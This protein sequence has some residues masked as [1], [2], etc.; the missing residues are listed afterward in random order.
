M[1][2]NVIR[3]NPLMPQSP[4]PLVDGFE[5]T[6]DCS[7]P[8]SDVEEPSSAATLAD[9]LR[10]DRAALYAEDSDNES[11]TEDPEIARI[12]N[13]GR[14]RLSGV[15]LPRD[16][17]RHDLR[18]ELPSNIGLARDWSQDYGSEHTPLANMGISVSERILIEKRAQEKGVLAPHARFFIEKE[19]SC[20]TVNFEP[21][22]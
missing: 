1:G 16:T 21:A 13:N 17:T 6:T 22:V 10:R 20:V 5:V 8:T 2:R 9:L 11:T 12:L 15:R 7:E 3:Y 4:P 18:R 19:A 14:A